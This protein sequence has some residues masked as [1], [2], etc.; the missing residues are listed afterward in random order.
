[1]DENDG[2]GL[3]DANSSELFS[4]QPT[5]TRGVRHYG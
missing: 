4:W 1:M 2:V 5:G 3:H